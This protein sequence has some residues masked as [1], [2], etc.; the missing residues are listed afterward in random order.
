LPH[1]EEDG[2]VT[3]G[4]W[5]TSDTHFRHK[6]MSAAGRGWRPFDTVEEHDE[7]LIEQW[8][9]TVGPKDQVWHLGD[10]GMG[11][12][13]DVLKIVS[14]LN[15]EIHLI[16]GNHDPVWPGHRDAHKHQQAWMCVFRSVQAFARRRIDGHT[17][18]LSHLPYVGDHRDEER[19]VQYRLR[20]HG[21][22]L[23]CG[24][25]H[26]AWAQ[27]GR[28]INVGVDVRRWKPVHIEDI[29]KIIREGA[30]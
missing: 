5:F 6:A 23:L 20:D 16:A 11:N 28:Q 7:F 10:V 4:V 30:T 17:V 25:V 22:W 29:A 1:L 14:Q 12:E 3:G 26:D 24:H 27:R 19:H 2:R 18:M 13:L 9:A 8:N 21:E 15:G